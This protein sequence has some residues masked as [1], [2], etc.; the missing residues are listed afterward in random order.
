MEHGYYC[1]PSALVPLD[2]LRQ[3]FMLLFPSPVG[4]FVDLGC[5]DGV[6]TRCLAEF[7]TFV[8][9][10]DSNVDAI[11]DARRV[12]IS[13]AEFYLSDVELFSLPTQVDVLFSLESFHLF[14]RQRSVQKRLHSLLRPYGRLIV[15]WCRYGWE[16]EIADAVYNIYTS[17]GIDYVQWGFQDCSWLRADEGIGQYFGDFSELVT[18]INT[19]SSISSIAHLL[20]SLSFLEKYPLNFRLQLNERVRAVLREIYRGD[21]WG[22][23]N[24]LTFLCGKNIAPSC[25]APS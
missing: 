23:K 12:P 13:N 25:S 4:E 15:G 18:T 16:D 24:R 10:V 22:G 1:S 21:L 20:S 5:G 14:G 8:H 6:I 11:G 3:T 17:F 9:G 19:K 2:A 7:G